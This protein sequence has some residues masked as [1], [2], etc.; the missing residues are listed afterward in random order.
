MV[1]SQQNFTHSTT[2]VLS[3]YV[4][5]YVAITSLEFGWDQNEISITFEF[6]WKNC[7]WNGPLVQLQNRSHWL[8]SIPRCH[9]TNTL[10][11]ITAIK[12]VARPSFLKHCTTKWW[13]ID[14]H[15]YYSL[16]N[17]NSVPICVCKNNQRIWSHNNSALCLHDVTVSTVVMS[18]C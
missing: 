8:D 2:A 17:I 14:I 6:W 11:P 10:S 18:Q 16:V 7:E 12:M 5:N 15:G 4:H 13:E 9:L 1:I 3:C